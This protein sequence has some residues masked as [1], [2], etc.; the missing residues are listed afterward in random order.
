[1][2]V[3]SHIVPTGLCNDEKN[4]PL[5][6]LVLFEGIRYLTY[7]KTLKYSLANISHQNDLNLVN[8][9]C[10]CLFLGY[11]TKTWTSNVHSKK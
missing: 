5:Y 9:F 1:M 2:L 3:P 8:I 10:L 6:H 4:N 11:S 7:R